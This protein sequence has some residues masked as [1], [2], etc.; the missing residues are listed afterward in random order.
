VDDRE[1]GEIA[2]SLEDMLV[3]PKPT[4]SEEHEDH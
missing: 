4:S 1:L 3:P 2:G